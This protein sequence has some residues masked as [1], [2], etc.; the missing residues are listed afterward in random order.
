VPEPLLWLA[1]V[2][3]RAVR[4]ENDAAELREHLDALVELGCREAAPDGVGA[5]L[6][7]LVEEAERRVALARTGDDGDA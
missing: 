4:L 2:Q 5:L 3:Q 7:S 1:I 6:E